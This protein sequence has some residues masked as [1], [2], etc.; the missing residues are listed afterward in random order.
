MFYYSNTQGRKTMKKIIIIES[1][2]LIISMLENILA[3]ELGFETVVCKS[4]DETKR[5]LE[6]NQFFMAITNLSLNSNNDNLQLL[7]SYDIPTIIF[8]SQIESKLLENEKYPNIIDY[9]F[10][11]AN[12]IKYIARI[13]E[14]IEYCLHK[15]VLVVDDSKTS[16]NLITRILQ[17]LFLTI[18]PCTN[19]LEALEILKSHP[20]IQAIICDYHMPNMNG[21][22]FTKKVRS[23]MNYI[24]IPLIITSSHEDKQSKIQFYKHGANDLISKPILQEELKFKLINLFLEKKY[25]E[26]NLLK[27]KMIEN[28]IITS[29][30]NTKGIITSVSKAFCQISGYTKE[31]LIGQSH[32]LLRHPDMPNSLYEQMWET[33]TQG[34]P[35]RGEVKNRKKDGEHYWV[36]AIIEPVFDNDNKIKGYYAIRLDITD[37]KKIEQISITDGLT[38][39][40]NRR[41]F[42]EVLPK[43]IDSSKRNDEWVC[44]LLMDIDH[45]K[46]YNDNYGHQAGDEVLIEFAQCLKQNLKRADDLAFRLGGEEFGIVFKPENKQKALEFANSVKEN[47]ENLKIKHEYSSASEYVTAS[48][49]LVCKRA[50]EI[51]TMDELFKQADDLLYKSKKNG[52]NQISLNES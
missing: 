35:W 42:N 1:S 2:N 34:E 7:A 38:N 16:R 28:Y 5:M 18:I 31:E 4:T 45:F 19:G 39:I 22:E 33:I 26:Q 10:K 48:M 27:N 8:S 37:K 3:K 6:N 12:G 41:H 9:V 25:Y 29:S 32:S 50:T 13:I 20:N 47:I 14:V 51:N 46:Q 15:K 40:F 23:D 24:N 44:F 43:I 52:R 21:L 30:T 36:D 17:K 49:G 11:D